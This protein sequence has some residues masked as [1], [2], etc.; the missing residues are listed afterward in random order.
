MVDVEED[1]LRAL[2]EDPAAALA[3]FVQ[4][5]PD[6]PRELQDEVGDFAEFAL[7][8]VAVDRLLAETGS[9]RVVMRAQ[10]VELR[11]E[12]LICGAVVSRV[13]TCGFGLNLHLHGR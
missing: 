9:Q 3:R 7:E 6:R 2:E 11:S 5:D 1:A 4:S 10:P 12:L 13:L 8:S